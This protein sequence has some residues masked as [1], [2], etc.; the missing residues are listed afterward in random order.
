MSELYTS[1]EEY[2]AEYYAFSKESSYKN[3]NSSQTKN[4]TIKKNTT[5]K[6]N[7][8]RIGKPDTCC[9]M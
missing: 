4:G 1:D 9:K 6:R 5:C 8:N 2:S 3:I 7:I